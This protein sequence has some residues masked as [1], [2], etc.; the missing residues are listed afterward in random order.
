MR[1]ETVRM[2]L[3]LA[4]VERWYIKQLDVKNEFLHGYLHETVYM[5]QPPGFKDSTHHDY[6]CLLQ[7]NYIWFETSSKSLLEFEFICSTGDLALF[8]Y[9]NEKSVQLLLLYTDDMVLTGN[10]QALITKLLA[11]LSEKFIIKTWVPCI[12]IFLVFKHILLILSLF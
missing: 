8:V 2:V 9:Q 6:V 11:T 10:D 4:I 1:N 3:H 7:K 5:R 12:I